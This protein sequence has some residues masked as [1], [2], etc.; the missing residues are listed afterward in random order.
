MHY[1]AFAG[2][3][4]PSFPENSCFEH[5][6]SWRSPCALI[7][8]VVL[9]MQ[10]TNCVPFSV[11]LKRNKLCTSAVPLRVCRRVFFNTPHD[12]D[13]L[14]LSHLVS[15]VAVSG[16]L[17]RYS[18]HVNSRCIIS[19]AFVA[20][21]AF[22]LK[23]ILIAHACVHIAYTPNQGMNELSASLGVSSSSLS[24]AP[25]LIMNIMK[26]NSIEQFDCV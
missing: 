17:L 15:L 13:I 12:P 19:L 3:F 4:L 7:L 23:N 11:C 9:S 22:S 5:F 8:F 24:W 1:L 14:P 25:P 16:R 21:Q 10:V 18:R 26:P 2:L 20:K 6:V